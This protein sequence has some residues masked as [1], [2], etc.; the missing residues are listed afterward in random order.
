[1]AEHRAQFI[2]DS[3]TST[4][5]VTLVPVTGSLKDEVL[6]LG[7]NTVSIELTYDVTPA[8]FKLNKIIDICFEAK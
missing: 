3:L 6:N 8:F 4:T 5:G 2:V 1:M 7:A